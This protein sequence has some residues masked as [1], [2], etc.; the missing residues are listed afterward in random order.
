MKHS[1]F[2]LIASALTAIG[3]LAQQ[4]DPAV[5]ALTFQA[6]G[7]YQR[8]Y[9]D[10]KAV[11]DD[12]GFKGQYLN[13]I[14]QGAVGKQF[15][16]YLR[17]RLNKSSF[18]SNFFDATD[19]LYLTYSPTEHI[20]VSGGKQTVAIGGYEYDR[21]PIDL[22]YCSEFWNQVPCYEWGASATYRF[23]RRDALM[24]QFCQS[25][26]RSF[27]KGTDMY[28]YNLQWN[29]T[30]GLW[31][32]IWSANMMEWRQGRFI[33]YIAL[34]NLFRLGSRFSL[35]LDFMNR[36]SSHQTFL[37]KDCSVIGELA[38][39]P[40]ATL[41]LSAKCAY[42]VN[43]SGSPADL[44]VVDGTELT[45]VGAAVEFMPRIR[46]LDIRLHAAYCY[47]WG[48]NS[49]PSGTTA[50][51]QSFMTVGATWKFNAFKWNTKD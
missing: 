45:R 8:N 29:G 6:R 16:Y 50:D 2:L 20:S 46:H 26:F 4:S 28:A 47:S 10:G 11:K 14:V 15:E 48:T 35:E 25:P 9:V 22:Y 18:D 42:D 31:S 40:C 19:M 41:Q 44:L 39:R 5:V 43:R 7:D 23:S 36:A 38:Y 17:Q 1:L 37:F 27:Y 13:M 32:T 12:C 3:A 33:N 51:R 24:F 49:N 21:A 30:H 34:G